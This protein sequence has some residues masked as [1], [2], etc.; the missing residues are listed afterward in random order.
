M[1]RAR[2]KSVNWQGKDGGEGRDQIGRFDQTVDY[3]V[4]EFMR[5]LWQANPQSK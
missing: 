2:S 4:A 5:S 1:L 3:L